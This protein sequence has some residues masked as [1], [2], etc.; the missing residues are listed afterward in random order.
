MCAAVKSPDA[1]ANIVK[2]LFQIIGDA[3][4]GIVGVFIS[5][6]A[7]RS[8]VG[9]AQLEL[10]RARRHDGLRGALD[11]RRGDLDQPRAPTLISKVKPLLIAVAAT[12]FVAWTFIKAPSRMGDTLPSILLGGLALAWLAFLWR[13]IVTE[14]SAPCSVAT[15]RRIPCTKG[16]FI[17]D[18]P[19]R[20][21]AR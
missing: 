15:K 10:E 8:A 11:R 17:T 12:V 9:H 19:I 2:T 4:R 13:A 7:A 16:I 20:T 6:W 1:A 14:P 21:R 18:L 3:F 5:L